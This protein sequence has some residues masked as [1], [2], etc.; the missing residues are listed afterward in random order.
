MQK[1]RSVRERDKATDSIRSLT[2][3]CEKKC[4][5]KLP[6]RSLDRHL[7]QEC[8]KRRRPCKYSWLGCTFVGDRDTEEMRQHE[9][10]ITV[11]F[12]LAMNMI[13]SNLQRI[14]TVEK[15]NKTAPEKPQ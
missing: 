14:N 3:S 1:D 8:P 5:V 9:E 7:S 4:G 12:A 11:H 15:L 2:V 13:Q 6:M 10:D